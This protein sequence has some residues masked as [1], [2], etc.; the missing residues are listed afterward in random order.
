MHWATVPR[1]QIDWEAFFG[2]GLRAGGVQAEVDA[3]SKCIKALYIDNPK[4]DRL[5]PRDGRS[6]GAPE[7]K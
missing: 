4:L 7:P 3:D 6:K 1:F 2:P 5:T